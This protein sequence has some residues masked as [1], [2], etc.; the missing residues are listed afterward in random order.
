MSVSLKTSLQFWMEFYW[1]NTS[2]LLFP[3]EV[4]I[5]NGVVEGNAAQCKSKGAVVICMKL[6]LTSSQEYSITSVQVRCFS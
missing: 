1:L 5:R 4:E 2:N 3:S 6:P